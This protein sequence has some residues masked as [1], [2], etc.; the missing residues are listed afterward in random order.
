MTV[1]Q[2]PNGLISVTPE[3]AQQYDAMKQASVPEV[4]TE[5]S[6]MIGTD[7]KQYTV[8]A[9][10]YQ[11]ALE[12]GW[13]PASEKDV[14]REDAIRKGVEG[15][16]QLEGGV[17]TFTNELTMG[18]KNYIS[19]KDVGPEQAAIDEE[20][21]NRVAERDPITHGIAATTGFLAPLAIPGVG[22][23]GLAAKG[24]VLGEKVLARGAAK[25]A[26]ESVVKAVATNA[27]HTAAEAGLGRKIAASAAQ[28][29]AEGAVYSAPK[30]AV[31]VAYGDV[32]QAAETMAI[33]IGLSGVLGAGAGGLG[34][35]LKG[36]GKLGAS[37]VENLGAKLTEK[38][39]NGVTYLD[40]ISRHFLGITDKDA[41]KLGPEKLT[42]FVE[43][44]DQLGILSSGKKVELTEKVFETSGKN[45]GEHLKDLEGHLTDPEVKKLMTSPIDAANEFQQRVMSKYPEIMMETHSSQLA[46]FTKIVKDIG[47]GGA[48]PSFEKLQ[49]IRTGL[50]KGKK[51]FDK[52]TPQAELYKE[53]GGIIKKHLEQ[54]A[55]QV[56]MAG[57]EPAK[58]AD[59]MQNKFDNYMAREL[60]K[61]DNPFK[62]TGRLPS[63][64]SV[65]GT[66]SSFTSNLLTGTTALLTGHPVV[67]AAAALP[68]AARYVLK[69][70]G[71]NEAFIGSGLSTL[72]KL[73]KDPASVPIIGGLLAKEGQAAL[74]RHIETIP[75]LLTTKP[76]ALAA[77]T[78]A[79]AATKFLGDEAIGL[80]KD[81]QFKRMSDKISSLMTNQDVTANQVGHISSAFSGTSIQLA[82]LVAQKK[83]AAIAYLHSQLPKNPNGPQPFQKDDWKPNKQDQIIFNRKL[84]IVMDPMT[85]WRHI[86]DHSITQAD[87]DTLKAVYPKVYNA[88]VEKTL[89]TAY[90]PRT[91]NVSHGTRMAVSVFA[92]VPLDPSIKNIANIQAAIKAPQ[93]GSSN[94]IKKPSKAPK[95]DNAPTLTTD[96]QRRTYG[97]GNK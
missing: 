27:V 48:E 63:L 54:G 97:K 86:Q 42:S 40:D 22:E 38:Q 72:R 47:A 92:G 44:A 43:R 7:G 64:E 81:Q 4:A 61:N 21:R 76:A 79:N 11:T 32:E 36:A 26:E 73:G 29:A 57:K 3:Q 5:P 15:T 83:L 14:A 58:F 51:A 55:Q 95:F 1:I 24:A 34:A 19:N 94:Q 50:Q 96:T 93:A 46:E 25:L 91:G 60:L 13:K 71:K 6:I 66:G 16:S 68:V 39:A 52:T 53:A 75:E 20:V 74:A 10:S 30:A 85:V 33:G 70:L 37:G 41:L 87:V 56:Y 12:Q 59:Y 28:Y 84:A 17:N 8:P 82:A 18:I 88:M 80:S 78:S 49:A 23:V 45:I 35:A 69:H 2:G 89:E 62:G 65:F 67:A 90:D 9:S 77:V 31:Q